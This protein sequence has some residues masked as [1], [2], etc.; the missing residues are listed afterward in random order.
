[1]FKLEIVGNSKWN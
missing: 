1:L